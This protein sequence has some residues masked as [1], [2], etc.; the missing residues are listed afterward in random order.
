[1]H[2]VG[3]LGKLFIVEKAGDDP[4]PNGSP[5]RSP[6]KSGLLGCAVEVATVVVAAEVGRVGAVQAWMTG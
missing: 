6:S 3:G 1:M 2:T 4:L 5:P